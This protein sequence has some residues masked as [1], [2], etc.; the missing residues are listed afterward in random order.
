VS[1]GKN[2][3]LIRMKFSLNWLC[4]PWNQGIRPDKKLIH[5]PRVITEVTTLG[6]I[7]KRLFSAISIKSTVAAF[8]GKI[9]KRTRSV[10]PTATLDIFPMNQSAIPVTTISAMSAPFSWPVS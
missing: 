1:P 5:A 6:W 9:T 7:Y 8:I 3:F 10:I 2:E 4:F